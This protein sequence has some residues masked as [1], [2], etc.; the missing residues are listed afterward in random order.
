MIQILSDFETMLQGFPL[1]RQLNPKM[2][3]ERYTTL[4]RAIVDQ[5]NYFQ[6]GYYDKDQLVGLTGVWIGTKVWCG[7][8]L[9]VDNFVVDESY[10]GQG[11]G[12][13]LLKWVE[14][15]ARE[16][17]CDMIGLDSYV[18]AEGA[19]RFYFANGFKIEGFHMTHRL[20]D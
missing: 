7:K 1:I 12:K 18:T 2:T 10:R 17:K 6:I 8:Y 15:R 16:E 5:R 20:A 19:H 4:L 13:K 9:E 3:I 11:V 14:A